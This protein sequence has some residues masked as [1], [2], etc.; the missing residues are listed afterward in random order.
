MKNVVSWIVAAIVAASSPATLKFDTPAGWISK[1]PASSMRV[2]EFVVP[3]VAGDSED[4][5]L[6]IFFFGG[7]GGSVQAN[8]DRWIGQIAQP[9]G[10]PSKEVA[11]M[12]TLTSHALPITLVDEIG[13]EH[14]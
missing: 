1:P 10:K 6:A 14:V 12:A 5:A 11:K 9:D 3:K 7:Q 4:A 2:A 13:R 8:L